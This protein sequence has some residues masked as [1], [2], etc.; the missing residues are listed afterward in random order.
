VVA[1]NDCCSADCEA[2]LAVLH[3]SYSSNLKFQT[4]TDLLTAV[5]ELEGA[6]RKCEQRHSSTKKTT[7][8]PMNQAGCPVARLL[9]LLAE[10]FPTS[11]APKGRKE[12][13]NDKK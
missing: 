10:P 4:M 12:N 13:R 7:Q 11:S 2:L 5:D 8:G 1:L 6:V 9:G 3:L